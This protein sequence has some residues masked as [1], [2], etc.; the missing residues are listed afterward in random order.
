MADMTLKGIT[1]GLTLIVLVAMIWVTG[2]CLF[3]FVSPAIKAGNEIATRIGYAVSRKAL[4][5][6]TSKYVKSIWW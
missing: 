3:V 6:R 2:R 1:L 5:P 4:R